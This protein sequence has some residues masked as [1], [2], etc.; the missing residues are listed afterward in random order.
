MVRLAEAIGEIGLE[1]GILKKR[2]AVVPIKTN[3]YPSPARR[4]RYSLLDTQ[5]TAELIGKIPIHWRKNLRK[6]LIEYKK[7]ELSKS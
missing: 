5:K 7:L 6:L 4:P 1:L 2:A 3:Q